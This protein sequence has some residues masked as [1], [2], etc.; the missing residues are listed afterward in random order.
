MTL[1]KCGVFYVCL[2]KDCM[3]NVVYDRKGVCVCGLVRVTL[4]EYLNN[5]NTQ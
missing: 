1:S 2:N 4:W 3:T 5:N